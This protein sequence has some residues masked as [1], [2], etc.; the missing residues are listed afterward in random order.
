VEGRERV[1]IVPSIRYPLVMNFDHQVELLGYDLEETSLR[2][3]D[4]LHLSLYWQ[5]LTEMDKSYTVFTH[6]LDS[7]NRIRGQ[8]D[9]VPG[10]GTLP[11]T[12]WGAGEIITDRYEIAVHSDAQPGR[13]V[14]EIGLYDAATGQRLPLVNQDGQRLDDRVLLPERITLRLQKK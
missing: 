8:K 12:S 11:T 3:G 6:L 14:L 13:Y 9:S 4:T 1:T 5:A 10:D 2:P 7:D